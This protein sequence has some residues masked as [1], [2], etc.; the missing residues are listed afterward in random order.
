MG[1][2]VVLFLFCL[3][4]WF[5]LGFCGLVGWG[6][7]WFGW[8]LVVLC[9]NCCFVCGVNVFGYG[10]GFCCCLGGFDLGFGV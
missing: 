5:G 8:G 6:V 10:F 7:V 4:C 1:L 3:C 9:F 2:V